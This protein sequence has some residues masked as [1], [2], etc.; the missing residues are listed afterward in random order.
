MGRGGRNKRRSRKRNRGDRGTDDGEWVWVPEEVLETS[1]G[2]SGLGASA[3]CPLP[4][5]SSSLSL[6][7]CAPHARD[8]DPDPSATANSS[9][10]TVNGFVSNMNPKRVKANPDKMPFQV[11][12]TVQEQQ[13]LRNCMQSVISRIVQRHREQSDVP[14]EKQMAARI[15]VDAMAALLGQ[16]LDAESY[17]GDFEIDRWM[18]EYAAANAAAPTL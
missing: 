18:D 17:P 1:S 13:Y 5:P 15:A 4:V 11:S 3:A 16:F 6:R 2:S 14:L 8:P 7:K 9:S 12:L 10:T